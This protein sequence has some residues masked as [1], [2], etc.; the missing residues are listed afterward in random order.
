MIQRMRK[1][2]EIHTACPV[3]NTPDFLFAFGGNDGKTIPLDARGLPH[4][5][6]FIAL[7]GM[8]FDVV[9]Q[10]SS[11]IAQVNHPTYPG[12]L[13]LDLR[14]T[15]PH[16]SEGKEVRRLPPKQ[17]ILERMGKLLG[18]P[19]VWGGNW[20]QGIPEMLK[21]YP[22]QSDVDPA[23]QTLWTFSGVDCSGLLYETTEGATPRNTSGLIHFG[24]VVPIQGLSIES[25]A[26]RLEPLDMILYKGHV[27]FV[28][29]QHTTIES[30]FRFGV[31]Q[32]DLRE[33]LEE[34]AQNKIPADI[35]GE[36]HFIVRRLA[37]EGMHFS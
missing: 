1:K 28:F 13:F 2:I 7:K 33:R 31:V 8:V 23:I 34:I 10:V 25:I 17:V 37:L 29:D 36:N 20:S 16:A 4:L 12:T 19:Y 3:L 14:F 21:L 26:Q 6:E 18:T 11:H 24:A 32:R 15:Q 35:P 30:R 27:L 22:P 9:E 5:N